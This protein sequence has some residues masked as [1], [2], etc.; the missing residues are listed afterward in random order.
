M[1]GDFS[2]KNIFKYYAKDGSWTFEADVV[3]H[4]KDVVINVDGCP[5]ATLRASEGD[6]KE[7]AVGH[8]FSCGLITCYGDVASMDVYG[9]AVNVILNAAPEPDAPKALNKYMALSWKTSADII[10]EGVKHLQEAFLYR[11]TGAFHTGLLLRRDGL[12]Y[13][14]IEDIARHNVVEKIIGRA[15]M[16]DVD[17]DKCMLLISGRLMCELVSKVA[18]AGIPILGSVS[19]TTCEAAALAESRGMT[20]IGFIREGRMNVYT[21]PARIAEFDE[22]R[23]NSN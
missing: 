10:F 2:E 9:N 8:L 5:F 20:L 12:K 15:L 21:H 7:L 3:A 11:K 13:F 14:L 23:M 16:Q 18:L 6:M 19:A 1:P 22:R 17:M 4:E